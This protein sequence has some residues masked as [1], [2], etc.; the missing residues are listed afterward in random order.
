MGNL[1][2][3]SNE[4]IT[5]ANKAD[6]Q[7]MAAYLLD[8]SR[9]RPAVGLAAMLIDAV[10]VFSP[11]G[12]RSVVGPEVRIYFIPGEGLL[13]ELKEVV[14]R[15]LALPL[16]A[17][18]VWWPVVTVR[19]DPGDHPLVLPLDVERPEEALA[20]FVH[21]FDLSRPHVRRELKLLKDA[22]AFGEYRVEQIEEKE[23]RTAEQRRRAQIEC[24]RE[25]T[26]AEQAEAELASLRGQTN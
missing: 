6:L 25:R 16:G 15:G 9:T 17:A 26:R 13:R 22:L 24:H 12:I 10:P 5:V 11:A 1:E 2:T 3:D 7:S 14:G 18:R 20:E 21:Q 4:L 8:S 23:R 19:S